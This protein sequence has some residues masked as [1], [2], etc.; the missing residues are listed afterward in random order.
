[1]AKMTKTQAR[2]RLEAAQLKI[3][4]AHEFCFLNPTQSRFTNAEVK[5]LHKVGMDLRKFINKLK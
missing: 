3:F 5:A 1:M 4:K 2:K